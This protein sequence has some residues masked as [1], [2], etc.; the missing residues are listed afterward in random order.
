[1]TFWQNWAISQDNNYFPKAYFVR[2]TI[3]IW[4]NGPQNNYNN[5]Q[6]GAKYEGNPQGDGKSRQAAQKAQ[7]NTQSNDAMPHAGMWLRAMR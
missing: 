1:M 4:W 2:E 6:S 3:F 7:Y 5:L